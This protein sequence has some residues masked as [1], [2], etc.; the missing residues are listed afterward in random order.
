MLRVDSDTMS[1]ITVASQIVNRKIVAPASKSAVQRA[2]ALA[3]LADGVTRIIKPTFSNDVRAALNIAQGLGAIVKV[4]DNE[5]VIEPN[6]HPVKSELSCMEAGLCIRMFAPIIA[7][8]GKSTRL[9][10]EGSLLKRPLDGI[11]SALQKFG[12]QCVT[13]KG[14]APLDI[15]GML[16]GGVAE[17]DGSLSSQ[18]L[19]GLLIALP[20]A[21]TDSEIVVPNLKSKPYIALTLE[22]IS[23]FG[24]FIEHTDFEHFRI[25]ANQNYKAITYKAEGDWS[26]AAFLLVAGLISGEVSVTNLDLNSSQA[27][28]A[29]LDAI[30]YARGKI[31]ISDTEICCKKTENLQAFDFDATECPDLFPPLAALAA[32]CQGTTHIKGV[33]RLTHKESNRGDVLKTEFAK[34]GIEIKISGDLMS[35]IGGTVGGGTISAHNDHRIAM[36]AAV[37]A[38]GASGQVTIEQADSVNKSY[39]DFFYDLG[40]IAL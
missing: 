17:I 7:L 8:F 1:I 36:A 9:S 23:H 11:Q 15:S 22:M 34:L 37:I 21:Q 18:V 24:G 27:D 4:V 29:V 28:K 13:N 12:A 25:K 35:V 3:V 16:T 33:G 6:I 39:P 10:G 32:Y 38:L 14:Y 26:G 20:K 5:I 2:I 19:T 31:S 40:L 30:S